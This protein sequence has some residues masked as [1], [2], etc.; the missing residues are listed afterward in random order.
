[1]NAAVRAV[2]RMGIYVGAKVFL[3]CEVRGASWLRLR[4][5]AL[6]GAAHPVPPCPTVV[7]VGHGSVP[8]APAQGEA[9]QDGQGGAGP[10]LGCGRAARP[11]AWVLASG[12]ACPLR[13]R[14]A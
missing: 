13:G 7:V 3:I 9:G 5:G 11:P 2:T 12:R 6:G 1:M 4:G 10:A 8:E 14:R